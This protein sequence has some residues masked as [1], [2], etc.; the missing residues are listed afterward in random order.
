M[1]LKDLNK[2]IAEALFIS[3]SDINENTLLNSIPEW[4]SMNHMILITK[5]EQCYK[6]TFSGDEIINMLS[7]KIIKETLL[8][9]GIN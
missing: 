9:K 7:V 5:L 8:S 6:V 1:H 2:T 4:D 3:E